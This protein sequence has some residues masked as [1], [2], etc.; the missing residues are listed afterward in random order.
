MTNFVCPRPRGWHVIRSKL[1][2]KW[3]NKGR[4]GPPA[5]VPLILG[6][7]HFSSDYDKRDRWNE[8]VEWAVTA[9]LEDLIPELTDEMQYCVSE[10]NSGTNMD[11][12]ARQDWNKAPSEKPAAADL[13]VHLGHLQSAWESIAGQPLATITAPLEFTGTKKRRLLVAANEAARP[14]WGDWNRFSRTGDRASFNRLRASINSAISPH[15]VD[16]VSFSEMAT[17]RFCHLIEKQRR[18]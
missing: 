14:P 15:E 7:R 9:G 10:L 5:P 3:E 16:H 4:H 8:T 2:K 6:G 11:Y 12:L 1:M 13:A 18:D 17:E